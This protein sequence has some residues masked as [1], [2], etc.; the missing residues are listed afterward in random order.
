LNLFSVSAAELIMYLIDFIPAKCSFRS[1][2]KNKF[3]KNREESEKL[4]NKALEAERQEAIQQ[5]KAEKKRA[6]AERI[7]KLSPEE[8]RKYEERERKR[9]IKKKQKKL[10]KKA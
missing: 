4:L 2:T 6:E 9:E 8:Q 1:E 10:I 3:K 7:A 5:K